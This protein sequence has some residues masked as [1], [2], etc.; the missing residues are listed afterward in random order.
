[1][2]L[3][4]AHFWPAWTHHISWLWTNPAAYNLFSSSWGEILLKFPILYVAWRHINCHSPKCWRR[5]AHQFRDPSTG[6]VYKLCKKH[7][8]NAKPKAHWWSARKVHSLAHI[9]AQIANDRH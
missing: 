5:G 1:M 3:A 7:H 9:H 6:E 2:I 8:P 4:S